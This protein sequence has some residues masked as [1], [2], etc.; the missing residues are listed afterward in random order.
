MPKKH[1]Y[2]LYQGREKVYIGRTDNLDRR[3]EEHRD[4][5]K[6]F[7]R[8]EKTSRLM[9]EDG[10]QD[11]EADQLETYRDGHGGKNPQYNKTDKG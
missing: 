2:A 6:R 7:T 4:D 5:G 9:S 8:A 10:A 11:R 1:T 3:L